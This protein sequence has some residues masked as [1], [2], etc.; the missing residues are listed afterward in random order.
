MIQ[1]IAGALIGLALFLILEDIYKVPYNGTFKAIIGLER[2]I[3]DGDSKVNSYLEDVAIWLSKVIKINEYK[4]IQMESDLRTA[5]LDITPEMFTA[6]CIVKAGLY[7]VVGLPV[8][9]INVPFALILFAIGLVVYYNEK[10][11]LPGRIKAKREAIEYEL[12]NF[13]F[14]IEKTLRHSRDITEMINSYLEIAGPELKHELTITMADIRSGNVETAIS[15]MERR[16]GSP[17][18]SDVC[19]GLISILRGDDTTVYWQS[20]ELKLEDFQREALKAEANKIPKKVN[21]LSMI[22]LIFFLFT[23]IVVIAVQVLESLSM[24]FQ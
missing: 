2:Q 3:N 16:V 19:R 10:K 20:L 18:M 15:R 4:H 5:R 6:N 13:V 9:A 17:M 12:S 11:S 21:R 22:I 24:L 8:L 1:F 14:T 7:I 23:W